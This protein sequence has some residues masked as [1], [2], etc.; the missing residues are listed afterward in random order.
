[1]T[2][3]TGLVGVAAGVPY[4]AHRPAGGSQG[5][6]L[7]VVLHL[8]DAPRSEAAMAAAL[9]LAGVPAWRAY[10]GLPMFGARMPAAG[11]E[12]FM[13]LGYED[14]LLKLLGPVVEQAAQ[15]LP[16]AIAALRQQLPGAQGP[17]A[18]V[19]G[20]AGAA[21]VLLALA[22]GPV[23]VRAA[24]LVNAAVRAADVIAAGERVFETTYRWSDAARRLADRLDFVHRARDIASRI[25]QPGVL[26]VNGE[27]D[28]P[29]FPAS[30]DDLYEALS[31]R[32]WSPSH[33]ERVRVPGLGHALAEEPG[34]DPAPQ[35]PGAAQVDELVGAWLTR[36]LA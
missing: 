27:D 19:G 32:W 3:T 33:V 25:P 5:A 6:P 26:L 15:E 1:M 12:A 2:S 16:G 21:A 18:L 22:E 11:P 14:A 20:S 9:P 34:I 35:T 23:S 31:A 36:R 10:L 13:R 7:V 24:V 30:A 29:A 28:D 17:V 8:M 4:L